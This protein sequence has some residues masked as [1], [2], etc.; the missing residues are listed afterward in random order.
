[1]ADL[2]CNSVIIRL[3]LFEQIFPVFHPQEAI[4]ITSM[5][6]FVLPTVFGLTHVLMEMYV[7]ICRNVNV[8]ELIS[9]LLL[10]WEK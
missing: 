3:L 4:G 2:C 1:M 10:V 9:K 6:S 8:E 5:C 7:C